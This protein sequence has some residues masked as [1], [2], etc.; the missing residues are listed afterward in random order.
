[1]NSDK[2]AVWVLYDRVL[3]FLQ[4]AEQ[5]PVE[6]QPEVSRQ[7]LKLSVAVWRVAQERSGDARTDKIEQELERLRKTY[8]DFFRRVCNL[9]ERMAIHDQ[10]YFERKGVREQSPSV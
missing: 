9:Q 1:V 7:L 6:V 8:E 3:E 4:W 2:P 5:H 10:D